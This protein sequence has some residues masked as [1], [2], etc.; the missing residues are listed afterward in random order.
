M[1]KKAVTLIELL[2]LTTILLIA[3]SGLLFT[4]VNCIF[5]NES[6][7]QAVIAANDAQYVLEEVKSVP[8][9]QI[10]T[11]TPPVFT[12]LNS[13]VITLNTSVGA[14]I[15][16]VTVNVSWVDKTRPRTISFT[17]RIAK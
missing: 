8:Y 3:I 12:N 13:E 10:S 4:F 1:K 9:N 16:E 14:K 6:N 11:Y 7:H 2:I 5:L 15:S 17:T